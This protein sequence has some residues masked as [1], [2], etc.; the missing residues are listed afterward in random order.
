VTGATG[1]TGAIG[2]SG[3][4]GATGERGERGER[5]E[6]G[7]NGPAGAAGAPG[8]EGPQGATGV[9]GAPG[10]NGTNGQAGPTGQEGPVGPEG[11]RGPTG[12]RGPGGPLAPVAPKGTYESGYWTLSAGAQPTIGR[13]TDGFISFPMRLQAELG[14]PAAHFFTPA[15]TAELAEG[16]KA[17]PGCKAKAEPDPTLLERPLAEP[18]NLCVYAGVLEQVDQSFIGVLKFGAAQRLSPGANTQGAD[19]Q[20]ETTT[21][22]EPASLRAQGTWAVREP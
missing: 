13:T 17:A 12:Q 1:P 15:A 7:P 4:A 14:E 10:T 6:N 18:G 5:G 8:T 11:G 16:K 22:A 2:A 9:T 3:N 20:F 19:I 21:A